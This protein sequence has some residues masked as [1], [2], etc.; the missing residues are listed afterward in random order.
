MINRPEPRILGV[1]P[2]W[3]ERG[4]ATRK[5]PESDQ[6]RAKQNDWLRDHP[7]TNPIPIKPE[8]VSHVAEQFSWVPSPCCSLPGHPFPIKSFALSVPVSPRTIQ[9]RVLDK[10]PL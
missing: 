3:I 5:D 1:N 9:F 2:A 4:T 10:S 6:I 7:E 8:P